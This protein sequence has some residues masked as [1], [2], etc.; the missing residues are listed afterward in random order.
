MMQ[1]GASKLQQDLDQRQA[2]GHVNS[3]ANQGNAEPVANNESDREFASHDVNIEGQ[4]A[5][6]NASN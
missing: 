2:D 5:G 4:N 6:S 3:N 1:S